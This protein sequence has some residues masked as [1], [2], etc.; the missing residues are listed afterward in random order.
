MNISDELWKTIREKDYSFTQIAKA[1]KMNTHTIQLWSKNQ[2]GSYIACLALQILRGEQP[3]IEIPKKPYVN[4][5]KCPDGKLLESL[6]LKA[7]RSMR[8]FSVDIGYSDQYYGECIRG[9]HKITGDLMKRVAH[10]HYKQE[11]NK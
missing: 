2:G 1:L 11:F 4:R 5:G 9:R 10:W 6:R 8:E 3:K 7:N